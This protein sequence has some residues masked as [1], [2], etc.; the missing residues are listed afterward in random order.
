[1]AGKRPESGHRQKRRTGMKKH[2]ILS[3]QSR[4][5]LFDPPTDPAAIVRHLHVLARR[6]GADPPAAARRQSA[7]VRRE[8]RLSEISGSCARRRRSAARRHARLHRG[9][10]WHAIRRNS[11][12]TRNA[13]K[14][15]ENISANF[16]PISTFVRFVAKTSAL[17]LMSRSNKRLVRIVATSS[18]PR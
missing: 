12:L 16:K 13:A 11:A 15:A 9:A 5:A 8:P 6:P 10:D 1:M 2:E 3:P 14:R 4:A 7:R 17:S 18:C